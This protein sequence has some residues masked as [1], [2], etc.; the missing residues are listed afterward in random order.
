MVAGNGNGEHKQPKNLLKL[1]L[2]LPRFSMKSCVKAVRRRKKGDRPQNRHLRPWKKGQA[3]KSPG[4]PRTRELLAQIVLYLRDHPEDLE[5]YFK[6]PIAGKKRIH[7]LV[8]SMMERH[9]ATL[10]YCLFGKPK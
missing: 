7:R 1:S 9:I 8:E 4:R 6:Q 5:D 3:P 2:S 10:F